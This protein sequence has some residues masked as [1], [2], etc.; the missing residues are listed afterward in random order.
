MNAFF[1][2]EDISKDEEATQWNEGL[3]HT[4]RDGEMNNDPQ[5]HLLRPLA[6]SAAA[7]RPNSPAPSNRSN[8]HPATKQEE[9]EDIQRALAM[10]QNEFGGGFQ[11][12][13]GVVGP[14]GQVFG[15]ANREYYEKDQWA[16][17]PSTGAYETSEIVPDVDVEQR[18]HAP[19]EPRMLK[20][21]PNG[22]YTPNLLTICNA[23]H[24]ARE[25][26]LMREHAQVSYGQDGD[27]WKGHPISMPKIVN[28]DDG[29]AAEP[30]SDD[31]DE[32]LAEVQRLMAFLGASNRSYGSIGALT[33]T[34]AIKRTSPASTRSRTLLELFLQNWAAAAS[35]KSKNADDVIGL[36]STTVGTNAAEGMDTPD[37]S[38]IDLQVT[39]GEGSK[40]DLFEL[41]DGLLWDTDAENSTMSDNYI[42]RPADVL[43]MRVYQANAAAASQLR[44]E[45]PPQFHVDKY[46][47]DN[48]A[49]TRATRLDMA[50]GKKRIAKI[51]EIEKKLKTWKHPKKNEQLDASLLLKHTLGHFSGQNR[52]DAAKADKTNDA[53]VVDEMDANPPHY[54]EIAQKL[55]K[56][57]ANIDSKL[58]TLAQEKEKTR[59]AISDMSKAPPPGLQPEELKHRYTLCGVA[60]KPSTTYVL[61]PTDSEPDDEM[62]DDDTTPR[63]MRWWRLEYEVS[64]TGSGAKVTKT[65]TAD[66]DVIRAVELEHSSALLVYAS[67]AALSP[68]SEALLLPRP[69]QDFV[70]RDNELF[71]AELQTEKNKPPAYDLTD[72]PRESIE[73]TSIDSTRVEGGSDYGGGGGRVSPPGY[74]EDNFM[75]H[76][77]FGL[78]PDI[79][80]GYRE[81]DAEGE[82]DVPVHEIKLDEVEDEG[83]GTEMVEKVHRPLE[84]GDGDRGSSD[85]VMGDAESQQVE[86]ARGRR[87]RD[88][89]GW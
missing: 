43:V 72:I 84:A 78:G 66:Y 26:L 50:K 25:A 36:F 30:E 54:E 55:E 53:T 42:E 56:V 83:L 85:T 80:Q 45:V 58:V 81:A 76:P 67:D 22:D 21:M 59:K 29:S 14:S 89:E 2:G 18:I 79:K 68:P 4:G 31:Q 82:D 63:G 15:P 57:I 11:Q 41:L 8:L 46:L 88:L 37:M 13:S 23:I 65:K 61:Y 75:G 16:L 51:E 73:R 40:G 12:E 69:L 10:S 9:D 17:V 62:V 32:L 7:T 77:G 34:N 44:V 71:A 86:V 39:I 48:I 1:D 49:T 33:Q 38:L 19:G 6:S 20:Q 87:Q 52:I 28:V 60:T 47:K 70:D 3:F 35:S 24:G 74:D 5:Q 64:A 27:W